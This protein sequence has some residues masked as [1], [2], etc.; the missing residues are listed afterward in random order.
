MLDAIY[1]ETED[2]MDKVISAF[3]R[4]LA[5]LRFAP[6]GQLLPCWIA[7]KLITTAL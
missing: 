3:Q 7:L 1:A 4:E 5:T 6:D 2:R